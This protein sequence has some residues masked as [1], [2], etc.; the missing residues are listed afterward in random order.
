VAEQLGVAELKLTVDDSELRAKINNAKQL[1]EGLSASSSTRR[2]SSSN[3]SSASGPSSSIGDADKLL[4]LAK[5]LNLNTSWGLALRALQEIDA[6]LRLIGAGD[7]V[8]VASSWTVALQQLQEVDA[9]LRLVGAGERLNLNTSW[10]TALQQ[11]QEIDSDLR[12]I[13]AGEK[14][15]L[16][17]SWTAALQQLQEIDQDLRLIGAGERLNISTNWGTALQ[18]L[19]EVDSDLRLISGG[20]QLNLATSWN[21]ALQFMEET[22]LDLEASRG[23][24]SSPV[25]GRLSN[26]DA[27]PGSPAAGQ[28]AFAGAR[29]QLEEDLQQQIARRT[30]VTAE[31]TA[32]QEKQIQKAKEEVAAAE[33]SIAAKKQL[34][35]EEQKA[36]KN[37]RKELGKRLKDS[38]GNAIIGGAFPALFGQGVGASAGGLIGGGLGGLLGG[39][40]GFGLSLV[41]TAIGQR[42]DDIN[43]AL[44]NPIENFD[45]LKTTGAL[46]SKSLE[47]YAEGLIE[48]GRTAEAA[49][50]IQKDLVSSFG[51][52][53]LEAF[54]ELR[55]A[56]DEL[57]RGFAQAAAGV[58]SFVAGPLSDFLRALAKDLSNI[59][60]A[61]RFESLAGRLNPEQTRQV[62]DVTDKATRAAQRRR[63]GNT[64]M[65]PSEE[66]VAEGRK[67]GIAEMERLLGLKKEELAIEK[68]LAYARLQSAKAFSNSF[69]LISAQV[70]GNRTAQLDERKNQVLDARNAKLL[71]LKNLGI[72]DKS[73]PRVLEANQTAAKELFKIE[74]ER[75]QLQKE[76]MRTVEQEA[77]KR[78]QIAQQ[79]AATNARRD[80]ALASADFAANPGNSTLAA[81]AGTA[82]GEAFMEQNRLQVEQAITRERQLQAQL[83]SES[84]PTRQQEIGAQLETAAQEIRAAGAEAGA[85]LAERASQ[86]AQS[87]KGARDALR[88][89]LEGGYKFL[90][91]GAK[92]DLRAQAQA[93]V[94]RGKA[95]GLIRQN[96]GVASSK[97]LFEAAEFVRNVE[98]QQAAIAQQQALID[99]LRENTVAE[100]SI[101]ISVTSNGDG[102][103][104]VDQNTALK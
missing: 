49:A 63:G 25:T 86:A 19:Q 7:R 89:T 61:A 66:D 92:A 3:S 64:F 67:A 51:P 44:E 79:I 82:E 48:T 21:R 24:P 68:N 30:N 104:T 81:R 73:D 101:K 57:N 83:A 32:A 28:D 88:S 91:P 54:A 33:K 5:K 26:G 20:R 96:L 100:R 1:I 23:G 27:I 8:N 2:S 31:I 36:A 47:K 35:A 69:R 80:A 4:D 14:Q 6:D 58:A 59:G 46:S 12:L 40:F 102:S 56:S 43:K 95:S 76:L 22:L 10:A 94:A 15:D 34:A 77:I 84:D 85:A 78:Q 37:A 41:G 65:P 38:A 45:K 98:Q 55:S 16:R 74:E 90:S 11:L 39:N 103:W 62:R 87:L 29:S 93:D 70:Q 99:A 13:S 42:F 71:E 52:D 97:R 53:S 72:T 9:D 50:V 60:T 18:V 17:S 75:L